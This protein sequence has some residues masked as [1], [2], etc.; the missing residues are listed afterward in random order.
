MAPISDGK[1][2]T[3]RRMLWTPGCVQPNALPMKYARK[4]PAMP[5]RAVTKHPPGS[6]P[7]TISLANAPTI[8]PMMR[9]PIRL[10][11]A[12]SF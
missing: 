1:N 6:L 9:A 12:K 2:P 11:T 3:G 10:N 4:E 8:K 5:M 7:G